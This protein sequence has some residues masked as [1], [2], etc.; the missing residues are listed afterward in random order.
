MQL[1]PLRIGAVLATKDG[2]WP[3]AENLPRIENS[4]WEGCG[5]KLWW[6]CVQVMNPVNP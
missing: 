1:V 3:A 5:V 2:L 6:G 4:L